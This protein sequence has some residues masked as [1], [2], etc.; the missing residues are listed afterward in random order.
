MW[1]YFLKL[2]NITT[3]CTYHSLLICQEHGFLPL[4]AIEVNNAAIEHGCTNT[5]LRPCFQFFVYIPGSAGSYSI[6][7]FLRNNRTVF[8][9]GWIALPSHQELEHQCSSFLNSSPLVSER[10]HKA[11]IRLNWFWF[12]KAHCWLIKPAV[13]LQR[14]H[15]PWARGDPCF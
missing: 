15:C 10:A 8:Y 3:V 14:Q 2:N 4:L 12:L 11:W 1:N 13:I 7:K 5:S 6:F 9:S